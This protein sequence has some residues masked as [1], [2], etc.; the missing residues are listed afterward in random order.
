MFIHSDIKMMKLAIDYN[1]Q[2][3]EYIKSQ[4]IES[5]EV[6]NY[7]IDGDQLRAIISNNPGKTML[8][9]LIKKV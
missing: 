2:A 3:F 6:G 9:P 5:M 4:N 7:E 1:T 8:A